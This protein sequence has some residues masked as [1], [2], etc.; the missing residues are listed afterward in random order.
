MVDERVFLSGIEAIARGESSLEIWQVM[1]LAEKL[2]IENFRFGYLPDSGIVSGKIIDRKTAIFRFSEALWG[3]KPEGWLGMEQQWLYS[4]R[5]KSGSEETSGKDSLNDIVSAELLLR[6]LALIKFIDS[7][8][9]QEESDEIADEAMIAFNTYLREV[10]G[11]GR[12]RISRFGNQSIYAT[13]KNAGIMIGSIGG[14]YLPNPEV[15]FPQL[16]SMLTWEKI[17]PEAYL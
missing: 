5:M 14:K 11:K 13:L 17:S 12:T 7:L 6:F 1:N 4:A 9:D 16:V 2:Q 8:S 3:I 10:L 15:A